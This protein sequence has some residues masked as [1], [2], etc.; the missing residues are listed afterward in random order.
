MEQNIQQQSSMMNSQEVNNIE[1][2]ARP[3]LGFKEAVDACFSKYAT[4]S[5][6]SRRSEFWWFRLFG[7]ILAMIPTVIIV[8][9]SLFNGKNF[10]ED[11][12]YVGAIIMGFCV[13]V[14]I[15]MG[16]FLLI[17]SLAVTTRRL[18]D[19]GHS[20]WWLVFYYASYFV[21]QIVESMTDGKLVD[22]VVC[23]CETGGL[24]DGIVNAF[25][26]NPVGCSVVA[27]FNLLY[28]GLG[29]TIFIFMLLDSHKGENKYGRSPKYQQE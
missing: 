1:G 7:A 10:P 6:R 9:T 12:T 21:V 11:F 16:L 22:N 15:L 28:I 27:V 13:V 25:H 14:I 19:T 18:H 3:R 2:T 5:G 8:I 29:I 24:F 23:D 4:F 20:G 17:P 26:V